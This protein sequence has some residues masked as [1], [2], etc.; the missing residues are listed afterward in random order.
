M[1]EV[2]TISS[3]FEL[4]FS[5]LVCSYIHI[6]TLPFGR[7]YTLEDVLEETSKSFEREDV[8]PPLKNSKEKIK[9]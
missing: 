1:V 3:Q 9:S 7:D 5:Y 6:F 4:H 8:A 2:E